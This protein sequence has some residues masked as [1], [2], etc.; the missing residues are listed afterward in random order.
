MSNVIS[1]ITDFLSRGWGLLFSAGGLGASE[2]AGAVAEGYKMATIELVA[3]I[4][5]IT[6]GIVTLI[7]YAN[8]FY[9]W[10]GKDKHREKEGK[11]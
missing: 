2:V 10:C 3:Y 6:V 4:I 5:T 9:K 11:S 8:K 1:D 7:S